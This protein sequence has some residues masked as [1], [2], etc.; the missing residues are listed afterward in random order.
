MKY[1]QLFCEK[2]SEDFMNKIL[3]CYDIQ[4]L[5]DS[6]EFSKGDLIEHNTS[7]KIIDLIPDL[8]LYYLPCKGIVYLNEI[9]EKRC[10]TILS[11]FIKMFDFKLGRKE[12]IIN[13]KKT[14]FYF[15]INKNNKFFHVNNSKCELDFM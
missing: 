15:I 12:K 5:N 11:Q 14:I 3:M 10:I 7:D 8:I 2:P 6:K 13:K 4:N 1:F 9:D